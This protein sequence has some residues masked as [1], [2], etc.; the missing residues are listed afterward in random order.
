MITSGISTATT[1]FK[2]WNELSEPR[3]HLD[4]PNLVNNTESL[5]LLPLPD[6]H[7][8]DE[9]FEGGNVKRVILTTKTMDTFFLLDKTMKVKKLADI[10]CSLE[11]PKNLQTHEATHTWDF[12]ENFPNEVEPLEDEEQRTFS[13]RFP[14]YLLED[15]T[16]YVSIDENFLTVSPIFTAQ[17]SDVISKKLNRGHEIVIL[18]CSDRIEDTKICTNNNCSLVPPEFVTGFLGSLMS[19]L[20]KTNDQLFTAAIF[21]SEGLQ[22]FEKLS[23]TTVDSI[24]DFCSQLVS[25]DKSRYTEECYKRWKRNASSNGAQSGLYL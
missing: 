25:T 8:P 22:G 1:Q 13:L 20:T 6:V 3:N 11:I 21:P 9:L 14:I 18:G 12:G 5:Q 10:T 24:I 4:A 17:I 2:Q 7:I 15:Q 19:D 16:L 23:S